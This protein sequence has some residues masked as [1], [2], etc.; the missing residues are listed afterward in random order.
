MKSKC[1]CG[2]TDSFEECCEPYIKE[3]KTAESAVILMRSR[4]SAYATQHADY[5]VSTT[6]NSTR[7]H[8]S[9]KAILEWSQSNQWI[10]LEVLK[11]TATTVEFK[12]YYLDRQLQMQIH[13]EHSTFRFENEKWFY[14]D[15]DFY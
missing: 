12:A 2:S 5:L 8:H 13:H 3:F 6:H 4:Y 10:K 14:V 1:Y 15:G 7:R 11:T 9:K